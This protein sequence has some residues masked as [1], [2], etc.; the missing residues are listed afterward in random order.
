M[1]Y[2]QI[3]GIIESFT[4]MRTAPAVVPVSETKP[5]EVP[6]EQNVTSLPVADS[7]VKENDFVE[8][9]PEPVIPPDIPKALADL[10]RYQYLS[11]NQSA[12]FLPR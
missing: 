8:A 7:S 10:I 4:P 11:P 1:D 9:V 5:E 6:Q 12:P 2:E 3:R